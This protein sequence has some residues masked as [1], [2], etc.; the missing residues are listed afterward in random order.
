M[1]NEMFGRM[2]KIK[3]NEMSSI[4]KVNERLQTI[5]Q[6]VNVLESLNNKQNTKF[7]PLPC[8]EHSDD[9]QYWSAFNVEELISQL[10]NISVK[11]EENAPIIIIAPNEK[12]SSFVQRASIEMMNEGLEVNWENELKNDVHKPLCLLMTDKNPDEYTDSEMEEILKYQKKLK[13]VHID[14]NKLIMKL[15]LE[16][17]RLFTARDNQIQKLNKC[18]DNLMKSK[19][20]AH[21]AIY[22]RE[23]KI[24]LCLKDQRKHIGMCERDQIIL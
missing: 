2:Q 24:F 19:V 11:N 20:Y 12:K 8:F 23:L 17:D 4:Q 9:E 10:T 14:R 21:F 18:I 7:D 3:K 5:H 6:D 15:M 13:M 1:F 22:T 16:R